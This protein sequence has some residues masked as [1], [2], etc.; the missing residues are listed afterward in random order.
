MRPR[1]SASHSMC[2]TVMSA[3][4]PADRHLIAG[5]D[6]QTFGYLSQPCKAVYPDSLSIGSHLY[7]SALLL[8]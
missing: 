8:A 5:K 4:G 6:F 7:H 3:S 1:A 2:V